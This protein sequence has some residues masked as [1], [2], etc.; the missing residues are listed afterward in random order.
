[1]L[2]AAQWPTP[3]PCPPEPPDLL[4]IEV[5]AMREPGAL[6][7]PAGLLEQIDRPQPVH[8]QAEALLV[9]GLAQM[10]VQLAIIVL[11]QRG[12][13]AHQP[14]VDRERRARGQ[15]DADLRSRPGIV[16][17]LQHALAVLEDRILVLHD[18]VGGKA[19]VL[20]AQVHR[21]A[22]HRHAHAE[23]ARRLDLDVDRVL[24]PRREQIM[25]IGR[26]RAAREHQFGE[27]E[28][29]GEPRWLGFSRAQIG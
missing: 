4:R 1:M 19:A 6:R 23:L 29:R 12:A 11:G 7:H 21:A 18:D 5:D 10:G 22:R 17:Q 8:F 3:T 26:R 27:R 14:L 16:E 24:Q 13:V 25:V 28:P 9:L 2:E 20:L 15:R